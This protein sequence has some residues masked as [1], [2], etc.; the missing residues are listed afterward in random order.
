M[1]GYSG[2]GYKGMQVNGDEPMIERDFF[3]AFIDAKAISK[4]NADDPRKSSLARCART[5]EGV[6]AAGNVIS[7]KLI[8]EDE[9]IV[10]RINAHLPEQIRVWG[11]QRTIASSLRL[12]NVFVSRL[13]DSIPD[14]IGRMSNFLSR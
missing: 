2:T 11:I 14:A 4:A 13:A 12:L 9:D 8:I 6:H 3:R 10:D 7:L 1:I 5:D